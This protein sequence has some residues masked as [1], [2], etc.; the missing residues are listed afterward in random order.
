MAHHDYPARF[1]SVLLNDLRVAQERDRG[2]RVFDAVGERVLPGAAPG[3]A[4]M[5]GQ[6][7][8]TRTTNRLREIEVLLVTRGAVQQQYGRMRSRAAGQ[9]EHGVHGLAMTDDL[10]GCHAWRVKGVLGRITGNRRGRRLGASVRHQKEREEECGESQGAH[11][12]FLL[13]G[14]GHTGR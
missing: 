1:Q 5:Q 13:F 14:G 12:H 10:Q 7:V 8:P 2:L 11:D 6:G 4:V 3:S 9:I